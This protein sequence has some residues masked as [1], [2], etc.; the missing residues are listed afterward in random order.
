MPSVDH[1]NKEVLFKI[2]YYGPGLGGKT[3]N[4]EQIYAQA[5][6][7]Q[8][9]TMLA[10]C[11]DSE[12]TLFFDLLPIGLGCYRGYTIRL[13]LCTVPGQVFQDQIRK[14]VLTGVDGVVFVA[15]SQ[16]AMIDSNLLSL[17]NLYE[18]LSAHG[19]DPE[20]V[21]LVFQYNKRD[22]DTALPLPVLR[23]LLEVVPGTPEVEAAA[24]EGIGVAET[25]K[26]IVRECMS[27][28]RDPARCAAGR[29]PAILP[30]RRTSGFMRAV[31]EASSAHSA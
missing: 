9:G 7:E 1:I 16:E 26:T 12:R 15:D 4:L 25:L 18:N 14:L 22:L 23:R 20:C 8:C 11:S 10:L 3:T 5:A 28:M 24:H 27:T 17:E 30:K 2:V 6:P 21:P 31:A 19:L 29:S 13:H